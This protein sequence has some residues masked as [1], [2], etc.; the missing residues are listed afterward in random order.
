MR[1]NKVSIFI[2]L[3]FLVVIT[4]ITTLLFSGLGNLV[5]AG[6]I[7]GYTSEEMAFI[8]KIMD[9]KKVLMDQFYSG[10]SEDELYDQKSRYE[11]RLHRQS[12]SGR[13]R[14]CDTGALGL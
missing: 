3:I 9:S 6:A 8:K 7:G 2:G 10:L 11:R 4:S 12:L 1:N 14:A 13:R 5:F